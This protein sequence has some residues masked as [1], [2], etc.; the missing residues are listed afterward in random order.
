[1]NRL[2]PLGWLIVAVAS[3]DAAMLP[4]EKVEFFE[5]TIRPVLVAECCECHGAEKTKGGLRLDDRDGWK[6]GGDTG[7]AIER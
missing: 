1:M 5:K 3:A 2:K 4:A 7:A 6:K